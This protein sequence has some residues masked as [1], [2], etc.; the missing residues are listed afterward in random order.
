MWYTS[1]RFQE[2]K[3]KK[4]SVSGEI[5]EIISI[6]NLSIIYNKINRKEYDTSFRVFKGFGFFS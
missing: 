3:N 4:Q 1:W 2:T 5:S 6:H